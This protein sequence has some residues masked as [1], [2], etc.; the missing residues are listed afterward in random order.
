MH[1]S[2][3]EYVNLPIQISQ[4]TD[5]WL[6]EVAISLENS[7]ENVALYF[8]AARFKE[9]FDASGPRDAV[10]FGMGDPAAHRW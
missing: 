5:E 3:V 2:S 1:N 10:A 4:P 8:L 9:R 6:K 7:A